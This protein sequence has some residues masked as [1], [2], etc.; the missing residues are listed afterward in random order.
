STLNDSDK[1]ALKNSFIAV[2]LVGA[3]A[4]VLGCSV[5]KAQGDFHQQALAAPSGITETDVHGQ[6]LENGKQ[7]ETDWRTAPEFTGL[8]QVE[9]PA[10]PNPV[11]QSELIK[12][13]LF[14]RGSA[15][16]NQLYAYIFRP[17]TS[18]LFG[19]LNITTT[20][21]SKGFVTI[22]LSPASF[23]QTGVGASALY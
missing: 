19:P 10:F 20:G 18:S 8:L 7:D 23:A 3:T 5:N 22:T 11:D 16:L 21:G 1:M 9:S 2:L 6:L 17:Q 13:N 4:M 15:Q 12:I 14:I